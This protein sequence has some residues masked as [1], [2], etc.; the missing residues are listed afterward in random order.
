MSDRINAPFLRNAWY[1]AAW[2]DE[3]KDGMLARTIMNEPL[4]F[5]RDAHGKIGC[6]EDRCCH[7]GA[8][9]S[10]G[11][12][13]ENG[14]QCGYHGL[15]FDVN[16]KC[17]EIPGQDS[18]PPMAKVKAHP[19]VE[20]QE[21]VWVWMGD[22]ALA[23]EAKIVDWPYHDNPKKYPHRKAMM[24][25]KV[26][27]MMM[28]DNLMDLTHLG[29]V[30]TKTIGGNPKIHVEAKMQAERTE[31]GA[32]L[33][34]WLLDVAPP[35]TY[36]RA[37]GF[38][39]KIDRWMDFEYVIPGSVKQWTGALNVG[40]GAVENREQEGFHLHLFHG[41]T[42]ETETT[43]HYFWSAANGY[44]QDDPQA[45]DALYNEIHPTFLE[46]VVIMEAQQQRLS[47]DPERPLVPIKADY[48]LT[49]ARRAF[50]KALDEERA[51]M[52]TAAE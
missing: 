48:A 1:Q 11:K 10:H 51:R 12:V 29:Y 38:T 21:F 24:P 13:V 31:T 25:I 39:G 16:G 14:L 50:Q 18:I 9:L 45:T 20:R 46:D 2:S 19:V 28:V 23:D 7:R 44:R 41:I 49:H 6:V 33:I 52:P 27:Y 35:P 17:V 34:R 37:V 22:P 36:V 32:R 15:V 8:P 4:L 40:M 43:T 42:P 3:L 47:A 30:H 5:F 26:N